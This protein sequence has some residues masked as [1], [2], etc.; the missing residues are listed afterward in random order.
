MALAAKSKSVPFLDAPKNLEGLV[1]NKDFDPLGFSDFLDPKWLREAELKHGRIC[2]L[3][4]LGV[5]VA[6]TVHPV[7]GDVNVVAAHDAAVK[8]GAMAQILTTVAALEFVGV[9]ALRE[10]MQGKGRKAGDFSFDPLG[11]SKGKTAAQLADM[12]LKE[13]EN[14]R[15]AMVAFSGLITQAALFPEKV[16]ALS[17]QA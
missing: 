9:I 6:S 17:T 2:M 8:S 13:L 14:G 5:I 11:F 12:E 4:T 10:T 3:A 16:P 7:L 15:L 1:G